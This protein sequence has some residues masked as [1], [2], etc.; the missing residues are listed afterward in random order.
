MKRAALVVVGLSLLMVVACVPTITGRV[1]G[2][3]TKD[4]HHAAPPT[5]KGV[6]PL[7]PGGYTDKVRTGYVIVLTDK[8]NVRA[9]TA[10]TNLTHGEYVT[11]TQSGATMVAAPSQ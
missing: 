2:Y 7:F 9:Q 8:G 4:V 10:Y 6:M 1:V 3:E 11:L 5:P